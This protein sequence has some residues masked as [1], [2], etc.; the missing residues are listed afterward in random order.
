M[1]VSEVQVVTGVLEHKQQSKNST[2]IETVFHGHADKL[3]WT[4][5]IHFGTINVYEGYYAGEC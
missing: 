4:I 1:F 3:S 5:S 2:D